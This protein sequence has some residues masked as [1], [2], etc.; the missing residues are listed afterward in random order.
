MDNELSSSKDSVNIPHPLVQKHDR[1]STAT[2][3]SDASRTAIP[4]RSYASLSNV[5][6]L[7]DPYFRTREEEI[8]LILVH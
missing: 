8:A 7:K 1:D 5:K 3:A 4:P 2:A 6:S